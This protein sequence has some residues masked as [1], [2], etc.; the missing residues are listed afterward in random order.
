M[1]H[2]CCAVE[3]PSNDPRWRRALW[4]A[5]VVNAAMFIVEVGA[6]FGADSVSL[7]ADSVDF[8]G[9]AANYGLS[10]V[11]LGMAAGWASRAAWV[12][13][14]TMLVYGVAVLG[15]TAW[16]AWA[17][18]APEPGTM[19]SVGLLALFANV[20]VA[21]LLFRFRSGDAN[22]RSVWLC[23]RNDAIGNVAVML[24]AAGVAAT[25]S[26]W[27]DLA[28]G[29]LM[30]ALAV[31]AGWATLGHA[32]SELDALRD[33]RPLGASV[34]GEATGHVHAPGEAHRHPHAHAGHDHGHSHDHGHGHGH[35]H[36]HEDGHAGP[37]HAPHAHGRHAH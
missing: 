14:A 33:G 1:A 2:E 13:G 4:I 35:G 27:P 3:G 23:T 26:A 21:V 31:S 18:A 9:D 25:G 10:L 17:G 28:V 32:R 19:G 12:K 15:K 6:S 11:A 36:G 30:G 37:A 5:L 24:A 22:M 29:A 7:L 16:G 34:A 8:A 20:S